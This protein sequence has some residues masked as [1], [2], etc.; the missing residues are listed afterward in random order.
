MQMR[1]PF[2]GKRRKG[3]CR[4][5][6]SNFR[7]YSRTK[8]SSRQ[9]IKI[10]KRGINGQ[11]RPSKYSKVFFVIKII[12]VISI[13]VVLAYLS[14]FTKAFEIRNIGV[15]GKLSTQETQNEIVDYLDDYLGQNLLLFHNDKHKIILENMYPHFKEIKINKKIFHTLQVRIE[16]YDDK[17]NIQINRPDG[18]KQFYIANELG[19]IS[20]IGISSE[21]LP[22]IIMDVTDTDLELSIEAE[23]QI[24]LHQE[25][26]NRD[27]LNKLIESKNDFEGKFNMQ[28]LEVIYLKRARELHFFTERYFYVWIDIGQDI[29]LQLSKLKKA[30]TSI[31]IYDAPIEY[32]DLRISGQN[33][34]KVIY[35]LT[36]QI[37][38]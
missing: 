7:S 12:A 32:I 21:T 20:Q 26:I 13:I 18:T 38:N 23:S 24:G 25:I 19:L 8:T 35:K 17:A 30:M 10:K 9:P 31:N 37:E 15:D 22:T 33:G 14:L 27:T 36:E 34:E 16:K 2:F 3:K 1:I 6:E 11:K 28:V 29:D 4:T 5:L